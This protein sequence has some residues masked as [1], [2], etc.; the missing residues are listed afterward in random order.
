[1]NNYN[2]MPDYDTRLNLEN[3]ICKKYPFIKR[4]LIGKSLCG[5]NIY[6]Y[7]IGTGSSCSLYAGAFHG[8]EWLTSLVLIKFL[9]ECAEALNNCKKI[10]CFR[11]CDFLKT[12]SLTIIPCINPDGVEI[13]Q[14]G[15][16]SCKKYKKAIDFIATDTSS[17][18][19][20]AK[21]VDLNHNFDAGWKDLKRLEIKNGITKPA[22][23]RYGGKSPESEPESKAL[24]DF[25][26]KNNFN[27]AVAFHSQGREIYW[28]F[29]KS[30]PNNSKLMASI[31]ADSAGYTVSNPHGLAVGGGFKDWFIEY[32][33][34]PAFTVEIGLG[35]NPLPLSDFQEEYNRLLPLLCLGIML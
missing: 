8:M 12:N 31:L 6:A 32:F 22:P 20:N 15:S 28:D 10:L 27:K 1:M 29:G 34:K 7:K 5:R 33:K 19:A 35:K 26:R 11:I 24:A 16:K 13:Q 9:E 3:N 23:T 18:Q 14:K 30:T 2:V 21:G 25:C 4:E 17:W